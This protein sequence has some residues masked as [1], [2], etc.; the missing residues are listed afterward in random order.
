[1]VTIISS[2]RVLTGLTLV[3]ADSESLIG[4]TPINVSRQMVED[5]QREMTQRLLGALDELA[6][7]GLGEGNAQRLAEGFPGCLLGRLYIDAVVGFFGEGVEMA[8]ETGEVIVADVGFE[9]QLVFEGDGEGEDE[10]HC[11]SIFNR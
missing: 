4:N 6:R 2:R 11:R 10:V 9:A 5:L 8:D 1:M 3:Q 7:V